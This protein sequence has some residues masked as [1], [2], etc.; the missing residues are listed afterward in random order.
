MNIFTQWLR[1]CFVMSATAV[2]LAASCSVYA[3]HDTSTFELDRNAIDAGSAADLP[4]D[5]N[6]VNLPLPNGTGGHSFTHTGVITDPTPEGSIFTSGG[7]KDNND[8]SQWKWKKSSNILDKDNITNAYAAAYNV[9]GHLVIYF[10]L[11]RLSNS[12]SAQVGFWF[13]KNKIGLNGDGTGG[14]GIASTASMRTGTSWSR[15]TS[16]TAG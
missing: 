3:V 14:G 15:A 10:G 8:I 9:S 6:T 11:D 1:S 4:D 5:W 16:A 13:L 12:G 2:A 7:S